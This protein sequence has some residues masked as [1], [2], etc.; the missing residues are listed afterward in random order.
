VREFE[1]T[2]SYSTRDFE[3]TASCLTRDFETQIHI[4]QEIS[5]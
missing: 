4:E 2:D 1:A 3:A 5:K